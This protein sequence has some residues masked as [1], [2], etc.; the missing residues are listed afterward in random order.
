M[1]KSKRTKGGKP[2]KTKA[3]SS[4]FPPGLAGIVGAL[5]GAGLTFV[6]MNEPGPSSRP[7]PP[8]PVPSA[9]PVRLEGEDGA[10][11]PGDELLADAMN[12][13]AANFLAQMQA[14]AESTIAMIESNPD[15]L[16]A[17]DEDRRFIFPH[18]SGKRW[19]ALLG[20]MRA[21]EQDRWTA[22]FLR[23][24]L[25]RLTGEEPEG[26]LA[27]T[28]SFELP[29]AE[30]IEG[31]EFNETGSIAMVLTRTHHRG[32]PPGDLIRLVPGEAHGKRIDKDV[33]RFCLAPD[34]DAVLYER[35][36]DPDD[37][38]G[39]RELK[40]YHASRSEGL[41][42]KTFDF[43]RE[44][45][46]TLGPWDP[47]GVFVNLDVQVYAGGFEPSEVTAY[48]I[49]AFSPEQLVKVEPVGGADG[50]DDS[51][52]TGAESGD[53]TAESGDGSAGDADAETPGSD[54]SG[55]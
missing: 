53:G 51:A 27:V 49:D 47:T 46:G 39:K 35:A 38:L 25:D 55:G 18:E 54:S 30:S 2:G 11:T 13:A 40:I 6:V 20:R 43:P 44:Q 36:A 31:A 10:S 15:R 5:L 32:Q 52:A 45:V 3:A 12:P 29:A 37:L 19:L 26:G 8:T 22:A 50:G 41:V 4:D 42:I 48:T 34:G 7:K 17:E 28:A 23:A 24:G 9:S 14:Q 21:E 33:F 1:G 16:P